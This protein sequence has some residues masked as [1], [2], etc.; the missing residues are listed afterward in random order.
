MSENEIIDLT[1]VYKRKLVWDILPC[2]SQRTSASKFG[3]VPGSPGG[4]DREHSLSH[5]RLDRIEPAADTIQSLGRMAGEIAGNCI[6]ESQGIAVDDALGQHYLQ[7][8]AKVGSASALAVIS[9]MV[10]IGLIHIEGGELG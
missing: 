2:P 10:D 7:Q 5:A 4:D 1:L 8:F 3:L 9:A 6:L